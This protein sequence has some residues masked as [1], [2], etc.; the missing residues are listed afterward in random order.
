MRE[1]LIGY[2]LDALEPAEH[3]QVQAQLNRDS[4][5]KR[6]L[7]VLS[8]SLL[9][10]TADREFFEPPAGLADR[11]CVF[12]ALRAGRVSLAQP[13]AT[14]ARQWSM[15]DMVVAAGIFL[16]ASLLF[17]PAMSQSRF[18]A[19]V[20]QCQNNLRSF[21][22]ALNNYANIHRGFFPNVPLEGR[23]SAAGVVAVRLRDLGFLEGKGIVVCPASSLADEAA[24]FEIPTA[25]ELESA[26]DEQL[27]VL[28]RRMGGSYGFNLGYVQDGR[29]FSP[30]NLH[31]ARFAVMA[32]S[33]SAKPP[34]H[35]ANHGGCG[36]NV[37]FED[38]HV[39][40]LTT[41]RAHGCRDDFYT[42]DKG[43]V[44]P[45][46]HMYDAVIGSS[47]TK[48]CLETMLIEIANP[49]AQ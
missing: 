19:R 18:A 42:N 1:Q 40:Y 46:L 34:Y 15:A 44:G 49:E 27:P 14:V 20:T 6:E 3:E 21:G 48:P 47:D 30:R 10:L 38:G 5:L 39:Q 17:F 4:G 43:V 45:G 11:T 8:R 31:R 28:H 29:Y 24:V 41:C 25:A 7:E 26:S 37:L 13:P 22:M 9:P 32:D 33:P 2:L 35:S 23:C 36:Q 16:A 12:V